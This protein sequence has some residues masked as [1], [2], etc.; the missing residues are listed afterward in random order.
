MTSDL[1]TLLTADADL[2][3]LRGARSISGRRR[4]GGCSTRPPSRARRS[5]C[6]WRSP[7]HEKPTIVR[8]HFKPSP[9]AIAELTSLL[10]PG[11]SS[12]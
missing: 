9:E 10:A 2:S 4:C 11:D 7:R 1:D 3:P 12:R 8:R 5:R 6:S